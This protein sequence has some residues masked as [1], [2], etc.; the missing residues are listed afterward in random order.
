MQRHHFNYI[1][2]SIYKACLRNEYVYTLLKL[3]VGSKPLQY[4]ANSTLKGAKRIFW[5]PSACK[6]LHYS[7]LSVQYSIMS[8]NMYIP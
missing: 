6:C 4:K 5:F 3:Q 2:I 8:K 1:K 7:V